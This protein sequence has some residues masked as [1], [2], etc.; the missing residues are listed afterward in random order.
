MVSPPYTPPLVPCLLHD[1]HR[2]PYK[3]TRVLLLWF[4]ASC[5]WNVTKQNTA[6]CCCA[7][8]AKLSHRACSGAVV[9]PFVIN[10]AMHRTTYEASATTYIRND[11]KPLASRL[12]YDGT[13]TAVWTTRMYMPVV[14]TG[15]NNQNKYE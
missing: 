1:T 9:F 13:T 15:V 2:L 3:Y 4:V 8:F 6:A 7:E 5:T 11:F 14:R 12:P 10:S